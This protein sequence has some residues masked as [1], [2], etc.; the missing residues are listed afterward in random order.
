MKEHIFKK[1]SAFHNVIKLCNERIQATNKSVASF[2]ILREFLKKKVKSDLPK[3][4]VLKVKEILPIRTGRNA[5]RNIKRKSVA[6]FI[7]RFD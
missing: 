7:Y 3:A 2:R 4:E 5:P 1:R 6:C